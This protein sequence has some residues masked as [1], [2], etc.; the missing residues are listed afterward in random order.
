MYCILTHL[1]GFY[2]VVS[3]FATRFNRHVH[4]EAPLANLYYKRHH[5]RFIIVIV[6]YCIDVD[7]NL[8]PTRSQRGSAWHCY[9]GRWLYK[10]KML[11][12]SSRP[13]KANEYF[14]TKLFRLDY[15]DKIYKLT[16]FGADRLRNII[17]KN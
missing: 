7:V 9:I 14:G 2:F 13:G 16:K 6:L 4:C 17:V 3:F 15:V 12:S 5:I 8:C 10:G 1:V 11:F